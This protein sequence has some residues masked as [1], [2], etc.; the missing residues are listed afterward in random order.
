M[1]GCTVRGV[2]TSMASLWIIMECRLMIHHPL[3]SLAIFSPLLIIFRAH[4]TGLVVNAFLSL[5]FYLRLCRH[6]CTY[7]ILSESFQLM[8]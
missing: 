3:T 2:M 7:L 4:L 1:G 6:L 8:L 5:S